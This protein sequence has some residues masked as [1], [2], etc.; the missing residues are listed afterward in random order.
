MSCDRYAAVLDGSGVSRRFHLRPL[1]PLLSTVWQS[2]KYNH[3]VTKRLRTGAPAAWRKKEQG[4]DT[5][6][7][8]FKVSRVLGRERKFVAKFL[9]RK[10]ARIQKWKRA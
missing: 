10:A 4:P 8:P 6:V 2:S 9:L 3:T 5:G 7:G 1:E